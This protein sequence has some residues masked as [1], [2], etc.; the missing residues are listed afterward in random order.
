MN[1]TRSILL[2]DHDCE[3]GRAMKKMLDESGYDV[4]VVRDGREALCVLSNNVF[5]VIISAL[6][7]P[8]VNGIEMM[9][10]IRRTRIDTPVIFVTAYGEVESYM[11]LMNMGAFEYL[12]KPAKGR[13]ILN[14]ANEA[15][16]AYT[17][18]RS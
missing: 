7:M 17:G 9:E 12:N 18:S 6:R 16:E 4:T 13:D 3:Y 1:D 14:V 15:V 2:V 10:E 5:D 11:D 8:N